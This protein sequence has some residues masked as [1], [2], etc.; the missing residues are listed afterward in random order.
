MP[1]EWRDPDVAGVFFRSKEVTIEVPRLERCQHCEGSGAEPGTKR[2]TCSECRGSGEIR[3][4]QGFFSDLK[5]SPLKFR[6]LSG[7][8]IVREAARSPAP[9]GPRVPNAAGVERSGCRR[10][11]FPI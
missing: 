11:F 10:G 1:R 4:S 2:S 5:K 8:S 7:A 6:A 9:N 3:M